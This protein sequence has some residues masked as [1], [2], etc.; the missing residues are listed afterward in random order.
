V[1]KELAVLVRDLT[2]QLEANLSEE[3]YK[4]LQ[5]K[6]R[7]QKAAAREGKHAAARGDYIEAVRQFGHAIMWAEASGQ[8]LGMLLHGRMVTPGC[9]TSEWIHDSIAQ[10]NAELCAVMLEAPDCELP[11]A[12][13]AADTCVLM[14]NNWAR[15]HELR[16]RTLMM[17]EPS[18]PAE[19]ARSFE[20]AL[21]VADSRYMRCRLKLALANAHNA[22]GPLTNTKNMGRAIAALRRADSTKISTRRSSIHFLQESTTTDSVPVPVFGVHDAADDDFDTFDEWYRRETT[23]PQLISQIASSVCPLL[24]RVLKFLLR[25]FQPCA[26]WLRAK[27]ALVTRCCCGRDESGIGFDAQRSGGKMTAEEI[28]QR[29]SSSKSKIVRSKWQLGRDIALLAAAADKQKLRGGNHSHEGSGKNAPSVNLASEAKLLIDKVN[30]SRAQHRD[31]TIR[32]STTHDTEAKLDWVRIFKF[33][34]TGKCIRSASAP[35][36]KEDPLHHRTRIK[37]GRKKTRM[38]KMHLT[39]LQ[40]EQFILDCRLWEVEMVAR[41]RAEY[42]Y[43]RHTKQHRAVED[44]KMMEFTL[45]VA[46]VKDIAKTRF[47]LNAEAA[48]MRLFRKHVRV[49]IA[50]AIEQMSGINTTD[51]LYDDLLIKG[52]N[53]AAHEETE[54]ARHARHRRTLV[55]RQQELRQMAEEHEERVQDELEAAKQQ[56]EES[57]CRLDALADMLRLEPAVLEVHEN[58]EGEGGDARGAMEPLI[59]TFAAGARG[60]TDTVAKVVDELERSHT[61]TRDVKVVDWSEGSNQAEVLLLV[62]EGYVLLSAAVQSSVFGSQAELRALSRPGVLAYRGGGAFAAEFSCSM[63]VAMLLPCALKVAIPLARRGRLGV[64][65]AGAMYRLLVVVGAVKIESWFTCTVLT[66]VAAAL[67][68][69]VTKTMLSAFA[70]DFSSSSKAVLTMDRSME[71]F[72]SDGVHI[73]CMLASTVGLLVYWA[74]TLLVLPHLHFQDKSLSIKYTPHSA[75]LVAQALLV[76]NVFIVFLHSERVV[77]LL[78]FAAI[79]LFVAVFIEV[80]QPCVVRRIN[81]WRALN[82]WLPTWAAIL[83]L[84]RE[85]GILEE[86]LSELLLGVGCLILLLRAVLISCCYHRSQV[87]PVQ[88][89][90]AVR[91]AA[92][93]FAVET[94]SV[95]LVQP[96]RGGA[97]AVDAADDLTQHQHWQHHQ[98]P[99]QR[100]AT[101]EQLQR[102]EGVGGEVL[103]VCEEGDRAAF[104]DSAGG[105]AGAAGAGAGGALLSDYTP[106]TGS[107]DTYTPGRRTMAM[108]PT[109]APAIA[110]T[111]VPPSLSSMETPPADNSAGGGSKVSQ[112]RRPSMTS[113][114]M[115]ATDSLLPSPVASPV[116]DT[117]GRTRRTQVPIRKPPTIHHVGAATAA[118]SL[119]R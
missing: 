87:Q 40:F 118:G 97:A 14:R 71:C 66:R 106:V 111:V 28:K 73:A 17:M 82:Y 108:F 44:W 88:N 56:Q 55:L 18:Q 107:A 41:H 8:S 77:V 39:A 78:A 98:H 33:Y 113:L 25:P 80:A 79:C 93:A 84:F 54:S 112:G 61:T 60:W 67:F 114:R 74:G 63:L 102:E 11:A 35:K 100:Q 91:P 83:G 21:V 7:R 90:A 36:R 23:L 31:S 53:D 2:F 65:K 24:L 1:K 30:T 95:D 69:P 75:V 92:S 46:A 72:S 4:E 86:S 109:K 50:P 27:A 38:I 64:L 76:L 94:E 105:A 37:P 119:D 9:C 116:G 45:F 49:F 5:V 68:L 115:I 10:Y 104:D 42:I 58:E 62:L 13:Q 3:K 85:A 26:H 15:G 101:F 12:L 59:A 99:N 52:I 43:L 117:A 70:C 110:L 20:R 22:Q 16:G 89:H 19:A 81:H 6:L 51:D 96:F 103:R 48:K 34:A 47:K 29:L 32:N 57:E